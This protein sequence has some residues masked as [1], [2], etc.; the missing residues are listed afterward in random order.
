MKS[1]FKNA[2]EFC[3]CCVCGEHKDE[4]WLLI[5]VARERRYIYNSNAKQ[6]F[7]QYKKQNKMLYVPRKGGSLI[8][9]RMLCEASNIQG[10]LNYRDH[11]LC[12]VNENLTIVY[13]LYYQF[14]LHVKLSLIL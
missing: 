7:K 6:Y 3:M 11:M 5:L 12:M 9:Q 8:D 13:W 1:H 10:G 14:Q 4:T 2:V